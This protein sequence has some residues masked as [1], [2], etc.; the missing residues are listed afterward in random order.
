MDVGTLERAIAPWI[1]NPFEGDEIARGESRSVLTSHRT[2]QFIENLVGRGDVVRLKRWVLALGHIQACADPN[3]PVGILAADTVPQSVFDRLPRPR[4]DY[5][6]VLTAAGRSYQALDRLA[7]DSDAMQHVRAHAWS[8]CF[9][10]SLL[11]LMELERVVRDH[12]VLILGETGTGKELV[13]DAMLAAIPG[14]ESGQA[15][16]SASLNAAAIPETLIESELFGHV[17]GAFTGAMESRSGR[18]RSA[19]LGAL[20]LDEVGDL[21]LTTQ[22]K[23]LR[24][25]ETN[26]VHPV[27]AD[28]SYHVD[29]R[30]IAATHKDL[31]TMAETRRFR[32]DLYERL[33][34][35]VIRLPPLRARPNDVVAIGRA[36]IDR[37]NLGPNLDREVARIERWLAGDEA[38]HYPW[39]GN[40]R[41]LQNCLRNLVLGL[42]PGLRKDGGQKGGALGTD[43]GD[44][45]EAVLGGRAAMR[46]VQRWYAGKI[47]KECGGNYAAA[48]RQMRIDR[49]TLKRW[50]L[51]PL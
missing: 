25:I 39:P 10:G 9:G 44:V 42:P 35:N 3:E 38:R 16:P 19:H 2:R 5:L 49:S 27:G 29:V 46:D 6:R 48:A 15:A 50:R 32:R 4:G 40:V 7:G 20:F 36:F 18:I 1:G 43:D 30:Y 41:E 37:L 28:E 21:P 22:V 17:K 11:H 31:E 23:L 26:E 33:A 13:A 34:G 51:P 12:D 14:D 24:V 45:P 47:L 8:A